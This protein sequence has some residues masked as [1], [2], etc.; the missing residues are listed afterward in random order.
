MWRAGSTTYLA[1]GAA[2]STSADD[3]PGGSPTQAKEDA[4]SGEGAPSP[5]RDSVEWAK[6][7][8]LGLLVVQNSG[9]F[10]VTRYSRLP[11]AEGG[12]MYL[13]SAVV[14]VVEATKMAICL[15]VLAT[16]GNLW[17]SLRRHVWTERE[18]T[19]RLAIPAVCYA[20]QNNLVF[21]AISN[22]SAAAAQVL[23][24]L[25][26]LT[27]ALFSVLLLGRTFQ[28]SQ[29]ASFVLLGLGVVL[30][31]TQDAKS[32]KAPTGA[33]PAVGVM[34]ALAAASLSGFA[35]VYLEKMYTSGSSSLWMR[36]VQL[37]IFALPLQVSHSAR[38]RRNARRRNA[39]RR[40]ARVP[41]LVWQV[42]AI[43]QWDL[44]AVRQDG[45]L[46]GFKASTYAVVFVQA[47]DSTRCH[48]CAH[49]RLASTCAHLF[50]VRRARA[51]GG[52]SADGVCHQIRGQRAQDLCDCPRAAVHVRRLDV[53]L[54]LHTDS[55]LW[56]GRGRHSRLDLALR[57]TV[58]AGEPHCRRRA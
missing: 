35:G 51:G 50:F 58:A 18:Q 47:R 54:R 56:C 28:P 34:A 37:G 3:E 38:R 24:Q 21:L 17:Q 5:A 4:L 26:T 48:P 53:R 44:D 12:L 33:S 16:H 29:W 42:V 13:S 11:D 49:T 22:L 23:Y 40:N 10:V 20:L 39:R 19:A 14:L 2:S 32:A 45:L 31:Q 1:S 8:S 7:S 55:D 27:T 30:V 43:M 6:W 41:P 57:T 46:Q 25:K 36:N 52:C 15:S 9:L